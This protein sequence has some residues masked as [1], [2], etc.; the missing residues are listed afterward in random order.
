MTG[1][2]AVAEVVALSVVWLA[3]AVGTAARLFSAYSAAVQCSAPGWDVSAAPSDVGCPSVA[4]GGVVEHAVSSVATGLLSWCS[5]QDW[6]P[7]L[8]MAQQ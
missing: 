6:S 5:Q 8:L 2:L 4:A 7:V 3:V 1:Q